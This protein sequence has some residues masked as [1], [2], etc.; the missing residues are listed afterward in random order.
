MNNDLPQSMK[1]PINTQHILCPMAMF[2]DGEQVFKIEG[3]RLGE[4]D[5]SA[6][7]FYKNVQSFPFKVKKKRV[8]KIEVRSDISVDV[9]IANEKGSSVLHKQGIKNETIGPIPTEDNKEMGVIIGIYPGDKA[10]VSVDIWMEK[11]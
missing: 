3:F 7:G 4:L 9:A 6:E 1:M 2:K 5:L 8:I 10:T 11:P